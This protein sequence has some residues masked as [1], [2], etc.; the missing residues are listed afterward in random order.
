ME[1]SQTIE[2]HPEREGLGQDAMA[3]QGHEGLETSRGHLASRRGW[4]LAG[5]EKRQVGQVGIR[6]AKTCG[7][8]GATLTSKIEQQLCCSCGVLLVS[9][10]SVAKQFAGVHIPDEP[11]Q[12]LHR[13]STS[14]QSRLLS[15][16]GK[17]GIVQPLFFW[18]TFPG[19]GDRQKQGESSWQGLPCPN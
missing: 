9:C 13:A 8:K 18:I 5:S 15:G 2:A 7:S 1:L 14:G 6:C 4:R 16:D 12:H 19:V 11:G 17:H 10:C 3:N